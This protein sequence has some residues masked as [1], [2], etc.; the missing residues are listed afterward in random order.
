M[1]D[2][3]PLPESVRRVEPTWPVLAEQQFGGVGTGSKQGSPLSLG[4]IYFTLFRHKRKIILCGLAGIVGAAAFFYLKPRIYQS[5]ARLFIHYILQ[6]Q[7]PITVG[8]QGNLRSPDQRGETIINSELQILTSHDLALSVVDRVGAETVLG[9]TTGEGNDRDIAARVVQKNLLVDVP[10]KSSVISLVFQHRDP[11]VVQPVLRAIVDSYLE[12]QIG[13]H[14]GGGIVEDALVQETDKLRARLG[15]TEDALAQAK[16]RAGI[17]S[18]EDAKV[19]IDA[20]KSELSRK[21]RESEAEFAKRQ[22]T[23]EQFTRNRSGE[24]TAA[25][26][27]SYA[28]NRVADEYR[29]VV[30]RLEFYREQLQNL[31][32]QFTPEN[33][34]VDRKSVV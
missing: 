16:I 22:A 31:M 11:T 24:S 18:L 33:A 21:I 27:D 34:R 14:G 32:V 7:G 19:E 30:V 2:S 29:Q 4:D 15:E 9:G 10:G 25:P 6:N 17:V 8:D 26:S 5:E 1:N 12:R 13:I 23:L 3:D 20:Q 28:P